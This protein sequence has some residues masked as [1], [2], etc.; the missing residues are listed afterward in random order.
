MCTLQWATAV[1]VHV[2]HCATSFK[3][4]TLRGVGEH[5][6]TSRSLLLAEALHTLGGHVGR[7]WDVRAVSI[8]WASSVL[9]SSWSLKFVY[10]GSEYSVGVRARPDPCKRLAFSVASVP[11]KPCAHPTGDFLC[12]G[13]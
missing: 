7:L 2:S 8:G 10:A 12:H 5:L 3:E 4:N 13:A 11:M 6:R 1:R 9:R